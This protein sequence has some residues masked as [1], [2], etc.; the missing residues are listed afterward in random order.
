MEDLL[1]MTKNWVIFGRPNCSYCT[2]AIAL[3]E[4]KDQR[5]EYFN[6]HE[7]VVLQVFMEASGMAMTVPKVFLNGHL[8][9]GFTEL[10]TLL[11]N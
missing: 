11:G 5:F 6:V 9:G 7:H 2:K 3:L 10:N 8:M 4:E 1:M